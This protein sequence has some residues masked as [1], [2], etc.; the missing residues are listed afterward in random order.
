M[1]VEEV[2]GGYMKLALLIVQLLFSISFM[3]RDI[4]GGL[5][6]LCLSLLNRL[7]LELGLFGGDISSATVNIVMF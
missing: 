6:M 4:C 5:L 2:F 1:T 7:Q 3:L